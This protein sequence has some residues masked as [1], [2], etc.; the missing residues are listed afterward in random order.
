MKHNPTI[1]FLI[2]ICFISHYFLID[3]F[4]ILSFDI[5]LIGDLISLFL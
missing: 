2:V 1:I 3:Y 5:L 4:L